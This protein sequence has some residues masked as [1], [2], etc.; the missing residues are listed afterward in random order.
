MTEILH[1]ECKA[2]ELMPV[3]TQLATE[4]AKIGVTTLGEYKAYLGRL[5]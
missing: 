3:L 4:M 5:N 1:I 2:K